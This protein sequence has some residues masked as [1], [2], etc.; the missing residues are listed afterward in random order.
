MEDCLEGKS[1]M[2][3]DWTLVWMLARRLAWRMVYPLVDLM[4]QMMV[5]MMDYQSVGKLG[6]CLDQQLVD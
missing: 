3:K 2:T 4:E 1:A 5:E 6:E